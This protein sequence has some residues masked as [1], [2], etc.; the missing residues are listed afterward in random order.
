MNVSHRFRFLDLGFN[1]LRINSSDFSPVHDSYDFYLVDAAFIAVGMGLVEDEV[2]AFDQHAR[3]GPN[4]RALYA[5]PRMLN[6][7]LRLCLH[8]PIDAFGCGMIVTANAE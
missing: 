5:K 2:R 1:K 3:G 8:R 4:L 6:E 7:Q